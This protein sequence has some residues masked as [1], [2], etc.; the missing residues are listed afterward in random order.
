MITQRH[1]YILLIV[2]IIYYCHHDSE[3]HNLSWVLIYI[4][5]QLLPWMHAGSTQLTK[6][7]TV[8]KAVAK[9]LTMLIF[10]PDMPK[11]NTTVSVFKVWP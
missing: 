3:W 6:S 10:T 5:E 8:P 4:L 7:N 2:I 9:N 11:T 1:R